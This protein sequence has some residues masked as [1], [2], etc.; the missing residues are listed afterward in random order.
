MI[1]GSLSVTFFLKIYL[2]TIQLNNKLYTKI[3]ETGMD[4]V[5]TKIYLNLYESEIKKYHNY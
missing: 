1:S 2:Y 3:H 5:I 4:I